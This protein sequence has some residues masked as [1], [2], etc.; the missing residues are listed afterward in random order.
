MRKNR[1]YHT[2]KTIAGV[3]RY[4]IGI[5]SFCTLL[6]VLLLFLLFVL[7]VGIGWVLPADYMESVL[8]HNTEEIKEAEE[9]TEELLPEGSLYGVYDTNGIY[10]YGTFEEKD[11]E[12]A[13]SY[14]EDD[15]IYSGNGGYYRFI[16][17]D[18]GEVCIAKYFIGT[19]FNVGPLSEKLPSPEL[20]IPVV[21]LVLF[22]IQI[23]VLSRYFG[24]YMKQRLDMLGSV[25]SK[26]Q[27]QELDFARE[28]SDLKEVDEVLD[29]LYKMKSVLVESLERQWDM[30]QR[31]NEQIA[32]LAHDIKTP[33][34]VIKGNAE[35]IREGELTAEEA[36]YNE[37]VLQS[38]ATIEEYL[39]MLNQI[40]TESVGRENATTI[41]AGNAEE[42]INISCQQ[43]S[44]KMEEQAKS[45]ICGCRLRMQMEREELQGSVTCNLKQILRAWGNVVG[46]AATYTPP[47]GT[48]RVH[49]SIMA[50][51]A[52]RYT[53]MGTIYR[54]GEKYLAVSIIDDGP[55]FSERDLRHA[56]EQFYQGDQSR[57]DKMHHGL[58]LHTAEMFVRGQGG[59]LY[60]ENTSDHGAKVT[61]CL[62]VD[63]DTVR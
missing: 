51:H 32:A 54:P 34:T 4:Y 13:W 53:R 14:Y 56:T 7:L 36:E 18:N 17:R 29:S 23:V 62:K 26:I 43:L 27:N 2:Q 28:H 57:H 52:L 6:I 21:G 9:V 24:K 25:T 1:Q 40:V 41:E 58:G 48:V 45:Q 49:M 47:G 35:L 11:R 12:Q 30:E 61:L 63:S 3:F 37:Y 39:V 46:N 10:R 22:I 5:F 38:A 15:N 31:R 19:R 59:L 50:E 8:R 60:L 20:L 42:W 33:L 44:D 55:G 16:V